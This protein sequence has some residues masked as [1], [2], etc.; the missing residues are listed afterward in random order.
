[1]ISSGVNEKGLADQVGLGRADRADVELVAADH[2]HTDADGSI[3]AVTMKVQPVALVGE[4][5]VRRGD[6]LLETDP[7]A[8]RFVVVVLAPDGL[9]R[10]LGCLLRALACD[11]RRDDQVEVAFGAGDR[12]LDG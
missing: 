11:G 3:R 1:M 2:G 7:D 12:P 5:L 10:E 4:P 9:R 6:R 8:S